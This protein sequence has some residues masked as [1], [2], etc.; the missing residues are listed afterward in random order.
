[1]LSCIGCVVVL[2]SKCQRIVVVNCCL[3]LECNESLLGLAISAPDRVMACI[4]TAT[5]LA[6][7]CCYNSICCTNTYLFDYCLRCLYSSRFCVLSSHNIFVLWFQNF[8]L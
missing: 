4:G 8:V 6:L 7:E 1:M 2:V 5:M 3:R